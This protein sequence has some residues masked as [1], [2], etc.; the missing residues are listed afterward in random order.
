MDNLDEKYMTEALKEATLALQEGEVPIGA[1]VVGGGKII[2]RTHNMTERLKD[3]T[4][5]AEM[6]AVTMATGEI[7]GKYLWDCTLYVTLEPCP[8][9]AGALYL[10]QISRIVYGASDTKR[11]FRTISERLLHPKTEVVNGVM[12][13]ECREIIQSFF[14]DKR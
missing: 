6:V 10:S 12:E 8:M 2:A 3:P 1:I 14:R 13:E 11:G 9:C 5:H 7:G 4:A